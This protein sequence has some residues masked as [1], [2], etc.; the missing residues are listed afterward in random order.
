[1]YAM[2]WIALSAFFSWMPYRDWH[3]GVITLWCMTYDRAK[4]PKS[5][6]FALAYTILFAAF[7]WMVT[8]TM[9]YRQLHSG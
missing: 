2:F 3:R 1:M 8:A 9:I 6:A 4:E 7:C 5:F